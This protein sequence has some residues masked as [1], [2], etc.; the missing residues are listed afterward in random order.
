MMW[1]APQNRLLVVCHANQIRSP[2]AAEMLRARLSR[3]GLEHEVRSSGVG[4]TPG[5]P[6]MPEAVAAMTRR[7]LPSAHTSRRFDRREAREADVVITL[8]RAQMRSIVGDDPTLFRSTFTLKELIRRSE[9]A[10]ER[11]SGEAW[12]AWLARIS[13][14]RRA[15]SL[16][17]DDARD[18]VADPIGKPAEAYERCA[19][20]L[21]A[22]V[23]RLVT[24]LR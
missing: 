6:M 22:L 13:L 8:A 2:M 21:S 19:D 14:D 23:D 12:P 18:D 15:A 5:R 16:L 20:E 10:G 7:G 1:T 24:L 11:R 17:G 3:A 4:A 9:Q